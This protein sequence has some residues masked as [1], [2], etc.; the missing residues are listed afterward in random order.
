M[1]IKMKTVRVIVI[2]IC[3][4]TIQISGYPQ[5]NGYKY[6][7]LNE[8][9]QMLALMYCNCHY[10]LYESKNHLNAVKEIYPGYFKDRNFYFSMRSLTR[11]FVTCISYVK[12]NNDSYAEML[13][14]EESNKQTEINNLL[15]NL[16]VELT[17]FEK[18]L[19]IL[20]I[21]DLHEG[22][23]YVQKKDSLFSSLKNDEIKNRFEYSLREEK[24]SS[25]F[26]T[27]QN[28]KGEIAVIKFINSK[29]VSIIFR[30]DKEHKTIESIKF[31][32][33]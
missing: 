24:Y 3:I 28:K 21:S 31:I 4:I 32:D 22:Y 17:P 2:L 20:D 15:E 25:F 10:G 5:Q 18:V 8:D 19:L 11:D 1:T 29:F 13:K 6:Y 26:D 12:I 30:F 9:S 33:E 14:I 16:N 7:D 23:V 27:Y